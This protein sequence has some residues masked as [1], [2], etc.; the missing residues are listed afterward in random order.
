[1]CRGVRGATTV[2][3]NSKEAIL[4]ASRELLYTIICYNNIDPDMVA[5]AYFTTTVDLNAAYP[6]T[7]ARQFGWYDVPLLCGHEISVPDG[8]PRCIRILLHW[9]TSKRPQE[10]IHVYLHGAIALRT[11]KEEIPPI[12]ATEIEMFMQLVQRV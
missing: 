8:L 4:F 1:M 9:N 6:A 10:I 7:A 11:D 5:S 3:E 12:P 2:T